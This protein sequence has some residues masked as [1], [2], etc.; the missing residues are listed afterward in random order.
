MLAAVSRSP[1]A[2][3]GPELDSVI[4]AKIPNGR[5]KTW[6]MELCSAST[7]LNR[8]G[9]QLTP[10]AQRP[11]LTRNMT[12]QADN[13]VKTEVRTERG[14]PVRLKRVVSCARCRAYESRATG[15][16]G[17]STIERYCSLGYSQTNGKP[18]EVCPKPLT[19]GQLIAANC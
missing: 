6:A 11:A 18:D 15:V 10:Q 3:C 14:A 19:I 4:N 17:G 9:R 5:N 16:M 2:N 8:S 12:S 1:N 13:Q 7:A